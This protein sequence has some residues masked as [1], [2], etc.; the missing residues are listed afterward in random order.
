[1]TTFGGNICPGQCQ[2]YS[3]DVDYISKQKHPDSSVVIMLKSGIFLPKR[4]GFCLFFGD[5]GNEEKTSQECE[6]ALTSQ[7]ESLGSC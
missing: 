5:W 7:F 1:M 3:A 6:T 2:L 4:H